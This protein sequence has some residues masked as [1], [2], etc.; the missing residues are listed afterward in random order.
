MRTFL[1]GQDSPTQTALPAGEFLHPIP[2]AALLLLIANDWWLKPSSWAPAI[3]TGKLSDV[4]GLLFFPLLLTALVDCLL[5]GLFRLGLD[6]D[7]SLRRWKLA[8]SIL[9]TASLFAAIKL[10]PAANGLAID[11]VG[12]LGL[13]AHIV[14]DPTDLLALPILWVSWRVGT[15]EI[16]LVP[17]GR[18]E[19]LLRPRRAH[20]GSLLQDLV[21]CGADPGKV[22]RFLEAVAH[23]RNHP[24][25]ESERILGESL[26]RLRDLSPTRA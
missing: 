26:A 22:G 4:A 23:Y 1:S 11:L 14:L 24:G 9:A 18:M 21:P 3:L 2:I 16:A 12:A 19:F 5:L 6:L 8:L 13:T 17:L 25:P 7:F 20:V 10:W 15:R